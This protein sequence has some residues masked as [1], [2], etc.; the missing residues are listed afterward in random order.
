MIKVKFFYKDDMISGF[1]LKGHAGYA[2]HGSDI[3]CSAATSNSISVINSLE[4]LLDVNFDRVVADEGLILLQISEKDIE[5]SQLLLEHLK[6]ALGEVSKE[7]PKYI[8][9]SE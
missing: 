4:V 8:K 9:I 1:E 3:V 2:D 7:Y 5:K 6:L